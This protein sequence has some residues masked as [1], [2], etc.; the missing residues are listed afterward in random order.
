MLEILDD[1]DAFFV[2]SEGSH[3]HPHNTGG[4]KESV[5]NNDACDLLQ[6]QLLTVNPQ[7]LATSKT[8]V[9]EFAEDFDDGNDS[10]TLAITGA[11]ILIN[12]VTDDDAMS[13]ISEST[14]SYFSFV[15]GLTQISNDDGDLVE[16][17][18]TMQQNSR[19]RSSF[20]SF[21]RGSI[22]FMEDSRLP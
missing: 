8:F 21:S 22:Y 10:S 6:H 20:L 9:F 1:W 14:C 11:S 2:D 5:P 3:Q 19:L 15:E 16:D 18:S 7:S 12:G 4:V 17:R 13:D